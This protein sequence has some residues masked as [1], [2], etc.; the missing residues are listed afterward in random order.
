MNWIQLVSDTIQLRTAVEM[1]INLE[2]H[3]IRKIIEE[4]RVPTSQEGL[5]SKGL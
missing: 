2:L 4:L 5:C 3:K 1:L